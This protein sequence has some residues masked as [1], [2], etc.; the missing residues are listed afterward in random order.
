MTGG[1]VRR[2]VILGIGAVA[3]LLLSVVPTQGIVDPDRRQS[4]H[5]VSCGSILVRTEWS[6]VDKC[7]AQIMGRVAYL[8]LVVVAALIA[9]LLSTLALALTSARA[10]SRKGTNNR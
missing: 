7:E 6:K 3:L 2:R 8:G 10:I 5:E 4:E 1:R 9:I